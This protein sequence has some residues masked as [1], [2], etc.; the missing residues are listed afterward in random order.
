MRPLGGHTRGSAIVELADGD[1][2]VGDLLRGGHFGGRW[3]PSVPMT[4]YYEEEPSAVSAVVDR[5]L[6]DGARRLLVGHGG[7]LDAA[8]VAAWRGNRTT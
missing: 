5:V 8:A 4:H 1:V 7:P 3:R 2:L 6:A